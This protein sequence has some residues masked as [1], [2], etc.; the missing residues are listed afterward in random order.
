[1]PHRTRA[2][3]NRAKTLATTL[4]LIGLIWMILAIVTLSPALA[5]MIDGGE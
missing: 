5:F 3:R 2:R 4:F 1:M